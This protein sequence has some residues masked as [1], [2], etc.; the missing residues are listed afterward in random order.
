MREACRAVSEFTADVDCSR[1]EQD[2]M[3]RS[4]VERQFLI[5]GKAARQVSEAFRK[6]HPEV[7]WRGLVGLRNVLA[8]EYGEVLV[9]RLWL[10][11]TQHVSELLTFLDK[12][13]PA[14]PG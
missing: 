2:R 13:V 8:H 11:A 5:L 3:L 7:P 9:E 10:F 1:F 6:A 12:V 4:A 14:D